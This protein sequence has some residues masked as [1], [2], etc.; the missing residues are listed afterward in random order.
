MQAAASLPLKQL[1]VILSKSEARVVT[2]PLAWA[3]RNG[4]T[5]WEAASSRRG[6]KLPCTNAFLVR[7]HVKVWRWDK[8]LSRTHRSTSLPGGGHP[9]ATSHPAGG[10]RQ[11][12]AEATQTRTRAP[13]GLS[14]GYR[15]R[16]P[17]PC[18]SYALHVCILARSGAITLSSVTKWS[19]RDVRLAKARYRSLCA[20]FSL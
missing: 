1:Y 7:G 15:A 16:R 9:R 6:A 18:H 3:Q 2:R 4:H 11:A 14:R 12:A 10:G 5:N 19:L 8:P 13:E 17:A 20:N